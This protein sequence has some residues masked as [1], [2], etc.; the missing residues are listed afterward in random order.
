L[1]RQ[2]DALGDDVIVEPVS[3]EQDDLRSDDVSIR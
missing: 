2:I 1:A 3:G